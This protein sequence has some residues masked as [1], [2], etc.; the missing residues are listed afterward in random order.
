M[1]MLLAEERVAIHELTGGNLAGIDQLLALY[2]KLMPEYAAYAPRMRERAQGT[3]QPPHDHIEHQWLIEVNDTPAGLAVF[4]YVPA[5]RCAIL[6]DLAVDPV[7]RRL[8]IEG[9]RRLAGWIL[10]QM[11]DQ[12]RADAALLGHQPLGVVLEA[13]SD[14]FVQRYR[15][16]GFTRLPIVWYEPPADGDLEENAHEV[17][18]KYKLMR[19]CFFALY[20]HAVDRAAQRQIVLALAEHYALPREHWLLR[21]ALTHNNPSD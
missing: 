14:H 3:W 17:R 20:A 2:V 18:Q 11:I 7:F 19:L 5:Y 6:L 12:V 15:A 4:K 1:S 9:H 13:D 10:I 16:Y 21:M 8:V